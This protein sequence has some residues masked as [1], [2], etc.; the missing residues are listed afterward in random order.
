M[1]S[2]IEVIVG[3]YEEFLLGY[4][5]E[6]VSLFSRDSRDF[7]NYISLVVR[8]LQEEDDAKLYQS[9]AVHA[10]T[11]SVRTVDTRGRFLASGGADDRIFVYDMKTRQEIRV[12]QSDTDELFK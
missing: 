12:S 8:I 2:N 11:A 5:V 3:T 6:Q 7:R 4:K 10:H 9:F 1:A